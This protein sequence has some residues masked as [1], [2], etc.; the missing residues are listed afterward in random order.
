MS[1]NP[2]ELEVTKTTS[3]G[4]PQTVVDRQTGQE[5]SVGYCGGA[6]ARTLTDQNGNEVGMIDVRDLTN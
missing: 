1:A 4:E 6:Y 5:L 2:D 3:E